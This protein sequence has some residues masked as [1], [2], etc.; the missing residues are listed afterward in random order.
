MGRVNYI[1]TPCGPHWAS[2][3]AGTSLDEWDGDGGGMGPSGMKW[4]SRYSTR[5]YSMYSLLQYAVPDK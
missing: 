3:H 1:N 5:Y 2:V 4:W